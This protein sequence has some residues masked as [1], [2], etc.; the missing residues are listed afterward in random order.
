MLSYIVNTLL[1]IA[2]TL[3]VNFCITLFHAKKDKARQDRL[4][5]EMH[6]QFYF[7][8]PETC[9]SHDFQLYHPVFD[10]LPRR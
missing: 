10:N 4:L 5:N 9:F 7:S 6:H 1:G 3:L 2:L 8:D